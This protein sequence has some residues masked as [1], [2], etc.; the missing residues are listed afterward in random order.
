MGDNFHGFTY[1]E[2]QTKGE[3]KMKVSIPKIVF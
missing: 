2:Q 3:P 1:K